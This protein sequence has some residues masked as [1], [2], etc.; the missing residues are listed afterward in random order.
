MNANELLNF[1]TPEE[2]A[3]FV[4]GRDYW[5]TKKSTGWISLPS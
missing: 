5:K 4:S 3:A 2:K 1:M